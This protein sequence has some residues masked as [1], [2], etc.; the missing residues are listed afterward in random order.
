MNSQVLRIACLVFVSAAHPLHGIAQSPLFPPRSSDARG[1]RAI[2]RSLLTAPLDVREATLFAEITGG[3]VPALLRS[4][5]PVRTSI[6]VAGRQVFATFFAVPDYLS[7][8]S[9]S[10]FVYAPMTPDLAQQIA[11]SMRASLPTRLMVNLIYSQAELRFRPQPLPPGPAMVTVPAFLQHNDSISAQRAA[12]GDSYRPGMLVAGHKK[13]VVISNAIYASPR[14]GVDRPV[15]IFGWHRL[16]GSPIQPLY[17]GHQ[18]TWADYSHGIRLVSDTVIVNGTRML[19]PDVLAD[20]V[21]FRLFSDEGVIPRPHYP[22]SG[23]LR[24]RRLK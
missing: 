1:G 2:M 11:A 22:L 17:S 24:Q 9:D 15:V 21:L 18:H 19:L 13:D 16:D 6:S 14:K 4:F 8:G 12:L 10:D 5:V 3:N 7:V 23:S 20:T